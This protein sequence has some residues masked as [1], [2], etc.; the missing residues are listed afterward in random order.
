[1]LLFEDVALVPIIF[2]LGILSPTMSGDAVGGITSAV[3]TGG[4]TV[5]VIWVAGRIVLP[6]LFHQAALTK[7]PELFLAATLVVVMAASLA[8]SV[9]GIGAIM[10]ALVAGLIIAETEYRAQVEVLIE[11]FKNLALGIFLITIGMSVTLDM[12]LTEWA[13]IGAAVVAIIGL[14]AVVTT[15]LLRLGGARKGLAANVGI[16]MASP[17]E[18]TLIVIA[19]AASAQIITAETASFWQMVCA[20]GLLATPS[21]RGSVPTRRESCTTTGPSPSSCSTIRNGRA[22]SSLATAAWARSWRACSPSMNRSS[23]SSTRA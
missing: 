14:K 6:R 7:R 17:S 19:A 5:A 22:R 16:L 9:A 3:I 13:L 20:I 1:M 23:P 2:A 8:T 4:I 21:W 18:T 12:S 10:G 15:G 11:P